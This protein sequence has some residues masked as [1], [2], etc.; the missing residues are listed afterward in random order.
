MAGEWHFVIRREDMD[1]G[2]GGSGLSGGQQEIP[3]SGAR[4]NWRA[5]GLLVRRCRASQSTTT[6]SGLPA[7][8]GGG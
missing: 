2:A 7:E 8:R 6:P 1:A 5:I 3:D 4:L